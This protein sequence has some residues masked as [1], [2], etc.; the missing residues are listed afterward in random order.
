MY[1]PL[2][3]L[4]HWLNA[5]VLTSLVGTVLLRETF[6]SKHTNADILTQKLQTLDISITHESAIMLAK[7]LRG[8]LW[9]WHIILGYA[10]IALLVYRIL[11]I[12]D[13]KTVVEKPEDLHMKAVKCGYK[14]LYAILTLFAITGIMMVFRTDLGIS[15]EIAHQAKELHELL[16]YGMWFIPLHVIGVIVEHKKS[17]SQLIDKMI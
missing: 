3:K 5:F 4:W 11:L 10:L 6:L 9:D 15:K 2:F 13:K 8:P 1:S 14:I 7:A 16:Y 17:K 12:F